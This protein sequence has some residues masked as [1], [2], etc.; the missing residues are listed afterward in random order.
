[1]GMEMALVK[2]EEAFPQTSKFGCFSQ[3]P[4]WPNLLSTLIFLLLFISHFVFLLHQDFIFGLGAC[5][6]CKLRHLQRVSFRFSWC[7]ECAGQG[8]TIGFFFSFFFGICRFHFLF[9]E[10]WW[11]NE[12]NGWKIGKEETKNACGT[13]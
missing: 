1:M 3:Q 2:S 9:Y 11:Q 8:F 10:S 7:C 5:R 6:S 4:L 13:K 12:F